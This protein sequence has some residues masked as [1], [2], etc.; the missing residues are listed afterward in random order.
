MARGPEKLLLAFFVARPVCFTR[1][2]GRCDGVDESGG[3][4]EDES[5]GD[6]MDDNFHDIQDVIAQSGRLCL[7]GPFFCA[8]GPL[9]FARDSSSHRPTPTGVTAIAWGAHGEVL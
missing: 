3:H 6:G 5:G 1:L 4:D 7:N 9:R 2:A 8:Q